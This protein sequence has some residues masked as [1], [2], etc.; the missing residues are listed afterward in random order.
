MSVL[1]QL[2]ATVQDRKTNPP[3]RSYTAQLFEAGVDRIGQ[4]I[5]EEAR[6]IVE[7]AHEPQPGGNQAHVIHEAADLIYHLFV[8]LAECQVG[9]DEVESEL[10]RRFGVSGLDEK[11]SRQ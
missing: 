5:L 9:L 6:E 4:K 1:Q 10:A 2:M 7:A 8:L 11:E 3:A